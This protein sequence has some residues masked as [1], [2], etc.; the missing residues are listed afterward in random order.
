M[1]LIVLISLFITNY[2]IL[3]SRLELLNGLLNFK[4]KTVINTFFIST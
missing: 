4:K 2:V 3:I 1:F